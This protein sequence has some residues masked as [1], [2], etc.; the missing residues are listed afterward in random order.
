MYVFFR[1]YGRGNQKTLWN[2]LNPASTQ[3]HPPRP[4]RAMDQALKELSP[5]FD[6]LYAPHGRPSIAPEKLLRALLIV[7]YSI[8]N[9][10]RLIEEL[11]YNL[12]Y[13]WFVGL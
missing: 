12:L 3:L 7:L 4:V 9:E 8:R 1:F 13:R 10:R 5:H 11:N 6:T 2:Q